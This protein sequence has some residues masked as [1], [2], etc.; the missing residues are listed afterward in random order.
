M[1]ILVVGFNLSA[2]YTSEATEL[3]GVRFTVPMSPHMSSQCR[4]VGESRVTHT[5]PAEIKTTIIT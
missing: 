4:I 2:L 3:T 1:F 5:T